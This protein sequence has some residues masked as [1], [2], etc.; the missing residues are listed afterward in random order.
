[1]CLTLWTIHGPTLFKNNCIYTAEKLALGFLKRAAYLMGAD[2][3]IS[4]AG[5]VEFFGPKNKKKKKNQNQFSVCFQS[6]NIL[7]LRRN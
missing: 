1:M 5:N 3:N 4:L 7:Q 2:Q 6:K